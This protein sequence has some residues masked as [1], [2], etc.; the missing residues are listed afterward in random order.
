ME[1]YLKNPIILAII[2][3]AVIYLLMSYFYNPEKSED[4]SSKKSKKSKKK[5]KS[6]FFTDKRE[7]TIL[8]SAI[9]ALGTWFLAKTYLSDGTES[10][11]VVDIRGMENTPHSVNP[12]VNSLL[13]TNAASNEAGILNGNSFQPMG[14]PALSLHQPIGQ[15]MGQPAV[16]LTHPMA[17]P[18]QPMG[19]PAIQPGAQPVV[20][21]PAV[22]NPAVQRVQNAATDLTNNLDRT[23]LNPVQQGGGGGHRSYNLLGTGLDIPRSAIPKVLVDY[24]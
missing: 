16:Q 2:V 14:Q 21:N 20:A 4:K 6:G 8:V 17:Q 13:G 3:G 11:D 18:T 22:V 23:N 19:Q 10:D 12:L 15:P 9:I 1:K 7:T 24:N 5:Q